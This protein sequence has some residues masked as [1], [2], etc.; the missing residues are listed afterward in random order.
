MLSVD[1]A[2]FFHHSWS[3]VIASFRLGL[4]L[5]DTVDIDI[6]VYLLLWLQWWT[7]AYHLTGGPPL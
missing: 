5:H 7:D 6:D 4:L 2:V 3:Q 1:V